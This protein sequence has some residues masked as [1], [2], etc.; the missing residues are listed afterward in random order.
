VAQTASPRD[1]TR[2]FSDRAEYYRRS[3]PHYPQTL[4]DFCRDELGLKP[5]DA[6]ADIGSGTGLLSEL[7]L[8][9]GNPVFAV[10]PNAQ[11]RSA[12]ENALG[13]Y[14]NFH[15]LNATAEATG[16]ADHSIQFIV[17]GTAF[18]W[19]DRPAASKEFS[20]ILAPGGWVLLVWNKRRHEDE[21]TRD[22][23]QIVRKYEIEPKHPGRQ[24][25]TAEGSAELREFFAPGSFQERQFDNLQSLDVDGL[26]ARA[27]SS[28]N[29]P[30]PGQARCDLMLDE[31]RQIFARHAR[32]GRVIQNHDTRLFYGRLK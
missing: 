10:E 25:L 1:P 8:S 15:S 23:E 12:A 20:R 18:H 4:L 24:L 5:A 30:L 28:S 14:P 16:L 27:L 3:R 22:Y 26:L 32:D 31:L 13:H 6:I 19:F 7:F 29:L 21:F 17:A 9:N 2:R 11:M